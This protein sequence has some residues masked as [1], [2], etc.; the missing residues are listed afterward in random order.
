MKN[1][2][3]ILLALGLMV[4]L[5]CVLGISASAYAS[6]YGTSVPMEPDGS[7]E[8]KYEFDSSECDRTIAVSYMMKIRVRL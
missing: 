6:P 2:L 4:V 3:R 1:R 7:T 5:F 8:T